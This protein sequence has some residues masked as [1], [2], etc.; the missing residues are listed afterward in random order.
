MGPAVGEITAC[1][2]TCIHASGTDAAMDLVVS[3]TTHATVADVLPGQTC[4]VYVRS[5]SEDGVSDL[6]PPG[7]LTVHTQPETP[8]GDIIIEQLSSGLCGVIWETPHKNAVFMVIK[9]TNLK[10]YVNAY[11]TFVVPSHLKRLLP[12]V[13]HWKALWK[14]KQYSFCNTGNTFQHISEM[15]KYIFPRG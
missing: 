2:I 9:M 8:V 13:F 15:S 12:C 10:E 6:E 7:S 1:S 4:K 3:G 5:V 11:N 14:W